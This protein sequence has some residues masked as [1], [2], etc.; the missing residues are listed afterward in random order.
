MR[1]ILA[2]VV[3]GLMLV[4]ILASAFTVTVSGREVM[5]T[6]Q[7]VYGTL[8]FDSSY[9]DGGESVTADS[10]GLS[11]INWLDF[12]IIHVDANVDTIP[13][14]G[15]TTIGWDPTNETV[16]CLGLA[17]A[18]ADTIDWVPNTGNLTGLNVRFRAEGK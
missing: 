8:A 1:K 6:R 17:S 3:A 12:T 13:P 9:P 10:L 16:W 18:T 4:P 5:G 2:L 14:L 7:V 15:V 11:T